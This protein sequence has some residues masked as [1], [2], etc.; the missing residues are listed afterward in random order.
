M[1]RR[2]QHPVPE[3]EK[4]YPLMVYIYYTVFAES[5]KQNLWVAI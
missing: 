3:Y 2:G 5:Y 1:I 4:A